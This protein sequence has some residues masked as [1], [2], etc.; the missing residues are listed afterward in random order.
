MK[1]LA[2]KGSKSLMAVAASAVVLSLG[3]VSDSAQ[4]QAPGIWQG[5]Y[6]GAHIGH[7]NLKISEDGG[8]DQASLRGAIGGIYAGYNWQLSN[9]VL[10]LEGD[11]GFSGAKRSETALGLTATV[12]ASYL[13]SLRARVGVPV[14]PALLYAT[15][16]FAW[17]QVKAEVSG[18][19]FSFSEKQ[20]ANGYVVG[21]GAE[22]Q[23]T[24]SL[25]GRLEGLHNRLSYKDDFDTRFTTKVN[26]IRAGISY[27]F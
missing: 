23:F 8:T 17:G 27:K 13:H 20:S 19:G 16:G 2:F 4:A 3:A 7:G 24:N 22:Y 21:L 5:I 25:V 6:L 9:L 18:V 14:G 12:K 1:M 15:G 10:G 26:V 11:L